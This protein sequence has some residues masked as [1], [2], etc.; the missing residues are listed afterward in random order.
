[1]KVSYFK[2]IEEGF[3]SDVYN[4]AFKGMSN[5][6]KRDEKEVQNRTEPLFKTDF[7]RDLNADLT[8]AIKNKAI[9]I[10]PVPAQTKPVDREEE[11]AGVADLGY[12]ENINFSIF[13]KLIESFIGE[14]EPQTET[15]EQ[16][17]VRWFGAYMG[18]VDWND[19]EPKITEIAKQIMSSYQKDKG[20]A[21]IA[22]LANIAWEA[23]SNDDEIPRGARNVSGISNTS[24][25][26]SGKLSDKQKADLIKKIKRG[27]ADAEQQ[28]MTLLKEGK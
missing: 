15:M 10:T 25:T 14:Q 28:L 1:M 17:I 16:Y 6:S 9:T 20:K 3:F 8:A 4:Q 27:D 26:N 18:N 5:D 21:G 13:N 11:L 7:I 23:T 19:Y 12:N 2:K 22:Q 24:S